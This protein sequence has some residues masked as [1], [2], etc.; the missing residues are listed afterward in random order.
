MANTYQL[1]ANNLGGVRNNQFAI[2][3]TGTYAV[4]AG[5]VYTDVYS[6]AA[7]AAGVG[8]VT[9]VLQALSTAALTLY[10]TNSPAAQIANGTAI[11]W[12]PGSSVTGSAAGT[13]TAYTITGPITAITTACTVALAGNQGNISIH[14][15]Y[16]AGKP[17]SF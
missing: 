15:G 14:A 6:S 11:W 5:D 2:L 3:T 8:T 16:P 9:V 17:A 1:N 12:A 10:V 4:G 13:G 7:N